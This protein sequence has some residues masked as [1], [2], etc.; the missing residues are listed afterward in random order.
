MDVYKLIW[1][2]FD[3]RS[4]VIAIVRD[5][6][7]GCS[8]RPAFP[9]LPSFVVIVCLCPESAVFG[10]VYSLTFY[11]TKVHFRWRLRTIYGL[12]RLVPSTYSCLLSR[13]Y[14]LFNN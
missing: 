1:N 2:V 7:A 4:F 10:L 14:D 3:P 8:S 11:A 12:F 5:S 9:A 6:L 13:F